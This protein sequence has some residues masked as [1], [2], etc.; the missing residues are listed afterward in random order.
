MRMSHHQDRG[1]QDVW[2]AFSGRTTRSEEMIVSSGVTFQLWRLYQHAWLV[3]LAFPLVELVRKPIPLWHVA[4]EGLF[5]MCFAVGYTWL[6]WPH[7]V[8]QGVRVRSRFSLLLFALLATLVLVLSLVDG[9]AWLWLF[10]GVSALV[11]MLLP[12]RRAFAMIVLLTLFPLVFTV[13]THR[14][15]T[16]VDWWWLVAFVL[17]VRGVGLDMIGVARMGRAIRELHT[18]RRE[19]A[20]MK[21][22][23]ERL[24]LARDL[25]DLL[26]QTLSVITLKSEVARGLITEDPARC[27]QELAE[28]EHISRQML[29]EVRK[30]VAGYRQPTLANELDG[31]RQLLE[32]AG[33]AYTI[34]QRTGEL[35][36]ALNTVLGWIVREGVTNVIRH[37]HAQ[38]CLLRLTQE[39]GTM[40]AEVLNDGVRAVDALE[41]RASQGTGLR[42]LRERVS[43]LGG[44]VAAD[45]LTM[46]GKPHFRLRVELPMQHQAEA[47]PLQEE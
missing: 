16:G 44:T 19:L 9:P 31:A 32:A 20:R 4:L 15:I 8:N 3:C 47:S 7:P 18:A 22:E 30:T 5:L 10:I 45:L 40:S 42:G 35:P 6:M 41:Q 24:R 34:E 2:T 29:R 25:H 36:P 26:G 38:H 39:Q 1:G 37:S 13:M 12:M 17:L 23:E 33:M 28:M 11:G 46:S 21:V 27:A 43:M 14:G